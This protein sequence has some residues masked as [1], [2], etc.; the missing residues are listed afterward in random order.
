MDGNGRWAKLRGK[1]R[2]FGHEAGV[3]KAKEIIENSVRLKLEALTLY[4]F[5]TENWKRPTKE[6]NGL[7]RLFERTIRKYTGLLIENNVRFKQAGNKDM[8]PRS[9]IRKLEQM[10]AITSE[11]TGLKLTLAIAYGSRQD[12]V[13]G[14]LNIIE[15]VD[16]GKIKK[17][18]ID[19]STVSS[20]LSFS[21]LPDLDL[22]IRTSGETRVSNFMLWEMAYSEIHF[23]ETLWPSFEDQE[24]FEI[25][26]NFSQSERR[27]GSIERERDLKK[28]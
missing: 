28:A 27:F 6:V 1:R 2:I 4:A 26:E 17:N 19:E 24:F 22:I 8:L 23:T 12:I 11:N 5:S 18:K 20:H 9:L 14:I 10:E 16:N 13:K 7:M 3:L 25:L 15:D 21:D